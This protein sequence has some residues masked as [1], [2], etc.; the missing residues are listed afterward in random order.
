MDHLLAPLDK[1]IDLV[2]AERPG[3][4]VTAIGDGGN[5]LGMGKVY[6][7]I[8]RSEKIL[9]PDKCVAVRSCDNLIVA[10]VSNWGGER[11]RGAERRAEMDEWTGKDMRA[12][13]SEATISMSNMPRTASFHGLLVFACRSS[14]YSSA[15]FAL[16]AAAG[17]ARFGATGEGGT[18]KD[19]VEKCLQSMEDETR[20]LANCV[21][22]S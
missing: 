19:I 18:A 14:L 13:R 16:A 10:S 22:V 20:I 5:E 4:V 21:E 17:L 7:D 15:G 9:M 8:I 12:A 11:M 6:D 1:V 3:V 2:K